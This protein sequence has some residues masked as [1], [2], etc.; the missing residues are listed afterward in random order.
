MLTSLG[1]RRFRVFHTLDMEKLARIN[2][3]AGRNNAGKTSLLEALFLLSGAGNIRMALNDHVTR[4]LRAE[5]ESGARREE[6]AWLPMFFGLDANQPVEIKGT[7]TQFGE[8]T[9][10]IT[11]DPLTVT[12]FPLERAN[13]DRPTGTNQIDAKSLV[14]RYHDQRLD[15]GEY[16]EGQIQIQDSQL[17]IKQASTEV[18]FATVIVLPHLVHST[19]DAQRLSELRRNKQEQML[20][21]ALQ[22][23]EPKLHSIEV[24]T[25]SGFP[26][27]WGDVGLNKLM[28]LQAMGNGMTRIASLILAIAAARGGLVL[29]DEFENGL[30]HSLLTT[31]WQVVEQVAR[32]FKVQVFATTHSLECIAAARQA[33]AQ[34]LRLYRLEVHE[35]ENRCITYE[36]EVFDVAMRHDLEVR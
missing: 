2:M 35:G 31:V 36:N 12:H 10:K 7:H 19:D 32:Q 26:M 20:L 4:G 21:D 8:P 34:D 5:T 3:I 16:V 14:F 1:I 25:V 15:T 11:L 13:G 27:I 29:V 33:I 9:L 22:I 23:I 24:N 17:T 30:H 28:P 18:P 6:V